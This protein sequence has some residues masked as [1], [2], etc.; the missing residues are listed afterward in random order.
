MGR[1][2]D[3]HVM[4]FRIAILCVSFRVN[5]LQ[6]AII[7]VTFLSG[8]IQ[9]TA[10]SQVTSKREVDYGK[11]IGELIKLGFPDAQGA[12]YVRSDDQSLQ[13]GEGSFSSMMSG[14]SMPKLS[15]NGFYIPDRDEKK[16][17]QFFVLGGKKFGYSEKATNT[18]QYGE[19][20]K[21]T[22][23]LKDADLKNDLAVMQKWAL[24]MSVNDGFEY[25]SNRYYS[26][27]L[28]FAS[29]AYQA[30][31]KKEANELIKIIF[32]N[33]ENPEAIIDQL[34]NGLAVS[35]L[36]AL[37]VEFNLK[38]DWKKYHEGLVQLEEKYPRG[39]ENQL[40]LSILIPL[41]KDRADNKP[42]PFPKI[43]GHVFSD[44]IKVLLEKTGAT[45]KASQNEYYASGGLFLIEKVEKNVKAPA[46]IQLT[47]HGMDGFIA[48]VA[49]I[50]DNTLVASN[51]NDHYGGGSSYSSYSSS[52][53]EAKSAE[54]AY[55]SLSKPTTRGEMAEGIVRN[56]LP[57]N[58]NELSEIQGDQLRDLAIE[59]WKEHRND[60]KM[61]LIKHYL[62]HGNN[63]HT[64]AL[65]MSLI[66]Q[67]TE[68]SRNLYEESVL[69]SS[70]PEAQTESV[71]TYVK[72]RRAKAK[73]FLQSYEKVLLE[74]LG[75]LT[76]N[77]SEYNAY[78]ISEAGGTRKFIASL[79]LFTEELKPE[80]MFEK[81]AKKGS[82][83]RSVMEMLGSLYS[84][85][86][87]SPVFNKFIHVAAQ[88]DD[89]KKRD[90]II[91]AL[92][93]MMFYSEEEPVDGFSAPNDES[94][95]FTFTDEEKKDW[96]KLLALDK[97]KNSNGNS[98]QQAGMILDKH[99]FPERTEEEYQV[100]WSLGKD[101]LMELIKKRSLAFLE[102]KRAEPLP[103]VILVSKDRKMKILAE[104]AEVSALKMREMYIAL[105][106]SE[107]LLLA[108]EPT[109]QAKFKEAGAFIKGIEVKTFK[110]D[111]K[112]ANEDQIKEL[113]NPM[114]DKKIGAQTYAELAKTVAEN[115]AL[116][117]G[118]AVSPQYSDQLPGRDIQVT[119]STMLYLPE[120]DIAMADLVAGKREDFVVMV[121]NT[122][123]RTRSSRMQKSQTFIF[124]K[125]SPVDPKMLE[126]ITDTQSVTIATV[127]KKVIE[128]WK[129]NQAN[130]KEQIINEL[131]QIQ[132]SLIDMRATLLQM[133]VEQLQDA[134]EQMKGNR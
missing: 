80:V 133:E 71:K 85:D 70:N 60:N 24:D 50:G 31:M 21:I 88:T 1:F 33:H 48:L 132:P 47:Q 126:E 12:K 64:R 119:K 111:D 92:Y 8:L 78:Q 39:W 38:A 57:H 77:S 124:D 53:Q 29:L 120:L 46:M 61:T 36:S 51:S 75:E 99:L 129:K 110:E 28:S 100:L 118:V 27:A 82:D 14:D 98:I 35:E 63:Q 105:N 2:C 115:M 104:L 55:D 109:S 107:R 25:Y 32:L 45:S 65:S 125:K 30:G 93:N 15:G 23:P 123:Q 49:L 86:E 22:G 89:V 40:G 56:V 95:T 96:L 122:N 62:E 81:L 134:L 19:S 112:I 106:Y 69:N 76:T 16:S 94:K 79:M 17:G 84:G 102:G 7:L 6:R 130:G 43:D 113:L 87:L 90:E 131:I 114:L 4:N 121:A 66:N 67:N 73:G 9:L 3:F 10:F 116:F 74:K 72:K 103:S 34:I 59:W 11:A 97:G 13:Y 68:E 52:D 58:N 54:D 5:S 127:T 91:Q 101:V 42:V 128:E 44:E 26:G 117:E 108:M 41:V 18:Y 37:F 83:T 20:P